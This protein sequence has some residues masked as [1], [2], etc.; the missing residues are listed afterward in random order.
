MPG[1]VSVTTFMP[2]GRRT[3]GIPAGAG[4]VGE[5]AGAAAAPGADAGGGAGTAAGAGAS[6]GARCRVARP[7]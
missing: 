6:L 1:G 2:V 7:G 5:I 3:A 4:C